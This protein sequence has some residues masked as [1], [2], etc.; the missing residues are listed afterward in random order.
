[1]F[2]LFFPELKKRKEKSNKE[3]KRKMK[4]RKEISAIKLREEN[5]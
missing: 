4:L 2:A 1:M 5:F 3:K